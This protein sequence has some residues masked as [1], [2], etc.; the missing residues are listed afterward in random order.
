MWVLQLPSYYVFPLTHIVGKEFGSRRPMGARFCTQISFHPEPA[1]PPA[2]RAQQECEMHL[3]RILQ[4]EEWLQKVT[5]PPVPGQEF[6]WKVRQKSA[7]IH[8]SSPRQL[9]RTL[10]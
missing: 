5:N 4:E 3:N 10:N 2:S 6:L 8:S 7:S 1:H 9:W